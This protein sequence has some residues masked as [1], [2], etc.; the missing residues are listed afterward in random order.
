MRLIFLPLLMLWLLCSSC[1]EITESIALKK[2]GS[3]KYSLNMDMSGLF[4]DPMLKGLMAAGEKKEEMKNIDSVIYFK[5]MPDSVIADNPDLWKRVS[6]KVLANEEKEQLLTT[7]YLDF[8]SVDEIGYVAKNMDKIMSSAK[9]GPFA[10]EEKSSE[11]APAGFL[12]EGLTYMLNGKELKRVTA[13]PEPK[14]G[15]ENLEMLKS[16]MG[17]AKYVINLEMP[18]KVKKVTIPNAKVKGK[19]VTIQ[20]PLIDMMDNKLLLDGSV[21]F[22]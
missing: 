8:K 4:K 20:A 7:I 13:N 14:E 17:S 2:D 9:A 21:K 3:G 11:T 5:D 1:F 18:G 6:M 12:T 10:S 15:E 19:N 22:K 16:F